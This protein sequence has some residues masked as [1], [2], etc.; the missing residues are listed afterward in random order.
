[1]TEQEISLL[2]RKFS[3]EMKEW[4]DK[5]YP[6]MKENA[7]SVMDQAIGELSPIFDTYVWEDAKR[8]NE[9]LN[10]PS[11]HKPCDYDPE[12]NTIEDIEL[13]G[14]KATIRIQTHAGFR[15][16]FR[17]TFTNKN[18]CWKLYKREILDDESNKWKIHHI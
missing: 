5:F 12:S 1:M 16:T 15:D 3:S 17:Y 2:Y 7:A 8:R 6:L 4:N 13:S 11:T 9:R 18:E 14:S 10:K